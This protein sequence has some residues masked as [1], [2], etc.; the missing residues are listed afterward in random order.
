MLTDPGKSIK[1]EVKEVKEKSKEFK[2]NYK[3]MGRRTKQVVAD[4]SGR[5]VS[6]DDVDIEW[7]HEDGPV[8]DFA[9][10]P[11][12]HPPIHTSMPPMEYTKTK[13]GSRDVIKD[14][15]TVPHETP[16]SI[17][18]MMCEEKRQRL[19]LNLGVEA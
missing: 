5:I 4:N 19:A 8:D 10:L 3:I 15:I 17:V 9:L 14:Q 2:L 18:A 1:S 13:V 12:N 16:N 6:L 11:T 7:T